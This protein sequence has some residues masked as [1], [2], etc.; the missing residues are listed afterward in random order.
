[1]LPKY[2]LIITEDKVQTQDLFLYLGAKIHKAT[3]I[4]QKVQI[5]QDNLKTLIDFQKLL[6]DINW[7]QPALGIPTYTL[8][9]PFQT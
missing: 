9:H 5:R 3:I 7:L 1:M 4:P 6:G 2:D 8:S